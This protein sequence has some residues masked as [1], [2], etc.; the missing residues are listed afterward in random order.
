L[1]DDLTTQ[2]WSEHIE[3]WLSWLKASGRPPLT[4]AL[5]KTQIRRLAHHFPDVDPWELKADD[6]AGF[7][8]VHGWKPETLKSYRACMRQFWIW[9]VTSGRT[10]TNPAM[11]LPS[12]R[13]PPGRPRPAPEA[14]VNAGRQ[15]LDERLALMVALGAECGLRCTEIA[16]LHTNNV[17]PDGD[18]WALE[19]QGKGGVVRTIPLT[20][21]LAGYLRHREAGY[22]FPNK[23]GGHLSA[24]Y[25]STLLSRNLDGD[26]T[27]HTLRHRFA[28]VAYRA[29]KDLRAV[30]DLLGHANPQTTARYCAVPDGAKRAAVMAAAA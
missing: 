15:L 10:E 4:I 8:G 20:E 1:K 22:Y 5:R 23:T 3:G 24:P 19:I 6:L 27:G 25:V 2:Q 30:Q 26:W 9:A 16:K 18:G 11:L 7:M 28:T 21:R 12:V 13:V 17:I 29:E 14:I